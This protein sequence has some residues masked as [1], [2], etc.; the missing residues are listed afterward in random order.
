MLL[1]P[2]APLQDDD[3]GKELLDKTSADELD[4][5]T[6]EDSSAS[7]ELNSSTELLSPPSGPALLPSSPQATNSAAAVIRTNFPRNLLKG[8]I[9]I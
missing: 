3:K 2:I 6:D 7:E 9:I 5:K 4:C 8:S 1:D